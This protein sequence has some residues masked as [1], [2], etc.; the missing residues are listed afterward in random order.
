MTLTFPAKGVETLTPSSDSS[1]S[2][3]IIF[4]HEAGDVTAI[5]EDGNEFTLPFLAGQWIPVRVVG[6][7]SDTTIQVSRLILE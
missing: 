1:F 4:A 2:P 6:V 7:T 5:G 3:S